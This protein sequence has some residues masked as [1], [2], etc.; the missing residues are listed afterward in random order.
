MAEQSLRDLLLH[1][2]TGIRIPRKSDRTRT[3]EAEIR[4]VRA[5]TLG[6]VLGPFDFV[7]YL[8]SDIE[9]SEILVFAPFMDLLKKKVRRIHI[10]THG[11][12]V[13]WK[14]HDLFVRDSWEV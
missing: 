5:G 3:L 12:A 4:F 8:E 1:N 9:E 6:D 11:K 10:G 7:D 14:L 13:H 2:S